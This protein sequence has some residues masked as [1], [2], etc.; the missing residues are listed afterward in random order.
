MSGFTGN[1]GSALI[2]GLNPS[3]IVQGGIVDA[4]GRWLVSQ[5]LGGSPLSDVNPEPN[6]SNIQQMILNGKGFSCSTGKVTAAANMAGSWF[7]PASSTKNKIIWSVRLFYNNNS[8][9]N[10]TRLI[11]AD[12]ANIVAGTSVIGQAINLKVGGAAPEAVN[13]MHYAGGVTAPAVAAST[14]P[15]DVA[16]IQAA[17]FMEVLPPGGFLYIPAGVAGG[18]ACYG[19]TTAAGFWTMT[20][21]WTEY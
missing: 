1:D 10:E 9:V 6:I 19:A 13:A 4:A 2:G 3:G 14:Q 11:T 21:H 20:V 5:T 16:E 17:L 8:Q 18:L 7:S 15:F 12:D